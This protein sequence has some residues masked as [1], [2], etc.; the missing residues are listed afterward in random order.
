MATVEIAGPAPNTAHV[1]LP[2]RGVLRWIFETMMNIRSFEERLLELYKAG[3]IGGVLHVCIGEEACA[4]GGLAAPNSTL[5]GHYARLA[6]KMAG[7]P[8]GPAPSKRRFG[9]F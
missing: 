2:N 3:R 8:E 9:L 5:G 1:R 6:A 4:A 7:L